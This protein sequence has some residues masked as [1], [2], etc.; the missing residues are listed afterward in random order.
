MDLK[1]GLIRGKSFYCLAI[2]ALAAALILSLGVAVTIGSVDLSTSDVYRVMLYHVFGVGDQ[3]RYGAGSLSDIVWYIRLPRL[4]LAAGVGASL[5]LAGVVMQAIVKNPLADPYVLGVS[6]GATL[7]A[8]LAILTGIGASLG[9]GY[10]GVM[11][12]LGAFAV[13]LAVV[14]LA[15]IGGRATSVKLILAGSALSAV[16]GAASNFFLYVKNSSSG[17][18][19][20]V[21]RW[22]MGSL[23]AA[24]W[25][26]NGIVLAVTAAG[27]VFFWTQH[28]TLNLMLLGDEQ[29]VTLGTDLHKWRIVYLLAASVLV[30][31]AVYA[32]G[33]IGFVGLIIPHVVR[34]LF[35][36]DHKKLVP[37]SVLLGAV[38][39]L[40]AD[41]LCR[42]LLKGRD[43]PVG[44]LTAM[45]GAPVFIYL[46][47]RKKYGF[48]GG[49]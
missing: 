48:G 35:G 7:G 11:A 44:I 30:G 41:V 32:A 33:I 3:A 14:S 45:L 38:F 22:T 39:L 6:S 4:V 20:A 28:R 8:T 13:S 36:T 12:F 21:V 42:V 17:A 25:D 9:G 24:S 5:S 43:L 31:F 40:W 47:A 2:L 27:F 34:M 46:M 19:E 1:N 18:V 16:C 23:A 37:L 49:D 29:A 26:V 15:N 10:V